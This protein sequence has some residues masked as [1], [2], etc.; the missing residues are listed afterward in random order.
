MVQ[1]P[2]SWSSGRLLKMPSRQQSAEFKSCVRSA[3]VYRRLQS[4]A[5]NQLLSWTR[6]SCCLTRVQM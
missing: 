3:E 4:M 6:L 5:L 1:L 2:R